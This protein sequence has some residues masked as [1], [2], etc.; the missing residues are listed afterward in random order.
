MERDN[1][2]STI[3]MKSAIVVLCSSVLRY[4]EVYGRSRMQLQV[5][6]SGGSRE[7]VT[8]CEMSL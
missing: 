1:T 7:G 4:R 3:A 8:I 5:F 2:Y 6:R